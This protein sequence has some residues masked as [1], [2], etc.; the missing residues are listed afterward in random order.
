MSCQEIAPVHDPVLK[1]SP[2]FRDLTGH[3]LNVVAAF[4]DSRAVKK[5]EDIFT[6]GACGEELFILVSG[7]VYAWVNRAD[8]HQHRIF[9]LKPGD[10]FGEMSIIA[11]ESRSAT[12]TASADSQ[13]LVFHGL[14]FYRII[15]E[16]PVIG[17]KILKA[18]RKVQNVWL[19]QLSKHLGDLMRW[20]ETARRRAICDELTG[21]YNRRFLEKSAKDRFEEGFVGLRSISLLMMDLD[22]IHAINER[23]GAKGGDLV[24]IATA[25][26]IRAAARPGD[27]CARLS[28]D[29][30]AILL[31]DTN[32]NEARL[33]AETIR[34]NLT[35]QK[36]LVPGKPDGT[37][38]TEVIVSTSIG[39]ASAPVH[40]DTWEKLNFAADN[41]LH[42]SKELGRNRVE[43]AAAG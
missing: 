14:D 42:R 24:F 35:V 23:H 33:M 26:V 1:A 17:V 29:E 22:K 2:M 25:D 3:E 28:G 39:I 21:L 36:V 10:F 38:Q 32:P 6:E 7:G 30:F 19:D 15:F 9:E 12:L 34:Y 16:H 20:G 43:V 41:A 27:I 18:I 11:N 31:P 8:G 37:G 40:A 5:G 13:L 4:L